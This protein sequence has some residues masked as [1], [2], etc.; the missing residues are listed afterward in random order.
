MLKEKIKNQL[1][2]RYDH[3]P[4]LFV[5]NHCIYFFHLYLL[6]AATLLSRRKC[7]HLRQREEEENDD[8]SG[9]YGSCNNA[10]ERYRNYKIIWD[11][12]LDVDLIE[13]HKKGED[14]EENNNNNNLCIPESRPLS[15]S[16]LDGNSPGLGFMVSWMSATDRP[17]WH[18][19]TPASLNVTS[20]IRSAPFFDTLYLRDFGKKLWSLLH[21]I[22]VRLYFFTGHFIFTCTP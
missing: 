22:F 18:V 4:W 8:G 19:Y 9:W 14:G 6:I 5:V 10:M 1:T 3:D 7:L 17:A 2:S 16:S 12:P 13:F 20:S 11:F 15:F 21:R